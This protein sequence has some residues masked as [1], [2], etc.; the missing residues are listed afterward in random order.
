M[1]PTAST[2][3]L[4]LYSIILAVSLAAFGFFVYRRFVILKASQNEPILRWDNIG[5]RII[6]VLQFFVGQGRILDRRF[7]VAGLMH[8]FIF[9]GFL[10]VSINTI[11]LVVGGLVHGFHLPLLG[12]GSFLGDI[13]TVF[14]DV[15]EV[16]VLVMVIYA[17]FRRLVLK[18]KRVTL[19]GEAI[20]VLLLIGIL[21]LTDFISGG[22][23]VVA[24]IQTEL[25][26]MSQAFSSFFAGQSADT[27]ALIHDASWWIHVLSLFL[28]LNLLPNS[29]HF[30]VI[31]SLPNVFLRRFSYGALRH[32]DLEEAE[33]FGVSQIEQSSW[34]DILDI[35]TCTECGR[36][37]DVCP[38]YNTGKMLSP[39][40]INIKSRHHLYEEKTP[41]LL[42]LAKQKEGTK[43][44]VGK[45]L[46]GEVIESEMLWACTTCK[47]CEEACPLFIEYIDRIVDMRRY[48]V[49]EEGDMA[50]ELATTYKNLENQ[51]NPW[52]LA[53]STRD[54]WAEGMNVPQITED[55]E[56][57]YWI[58]CSGSFDD[59]NV[60]VTKSM[61][62]IL[63]AAGTNYGILGKK[64]SCTGDPARRSGNEYLYQ[65]LAMTN[66]E[67]LNN[68]KFKK[69]ITQ[70]PHCYNTLKNEYPQLGGN[71]E[72]VHHSQFISD[73][74]DR[75][76]IKQVEQQVE[77]TTFH[78]PCYLGR[79]NEEY[80]APRDSLKAS[81]ANLVEMDRSKNNGFCCGAGGAQMWK[82]EEAGNEPVRQARFKEA[83]ETGAETIA[84]GCPF[85]MTM[86]TD[87]SKELESEMEVKDIAE[88]VAEKLV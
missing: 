46:V 50:P 80:D 1:N 76:L 32:I 87:A 57:L 36:C 26:P 4:I 66:I 54:E 6:T 34:K 31:T 72:V 49:L 58:G 71:Y 53:S 37:Q 23:K 65:M 30:H 33:N 75:G 14:R 84:T 35:Y 11:H 86:M 8:A 41:F 47:A 64:E 44:Y 40:E 61:I 15:F 12:P 69:I 60:K 74:I 2:I 19:S 52:G 38:A 24:G 29:K 45:A 42:Q 59:R 51:G 20:L 77:K 3:G 22:V 18:P 81:G 68:L 73:L 25:S 16:I 55:T 62:K 17:L 78:D 27:L 39:K 7:F 13:Y 56:V 79:H 85:C 28:F 63:N 43:E 21:M 5:K 83:R 9:W 82:E 67:T 48:L 88:I 70:C 10:A